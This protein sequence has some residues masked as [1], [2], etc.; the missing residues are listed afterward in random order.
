MEPRTGGS[1]DK[2][3]QEVTAVRE[4]E[5]AFYQSG[6]LGHLSG[7]SSHVSGNTACAGIHSV[8]ISLL[9]S[10]CRLLRQWVMIW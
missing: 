5:E 2:V 9:L 6:E 7:A 3:H 10:L 8:S 4:S 1:A